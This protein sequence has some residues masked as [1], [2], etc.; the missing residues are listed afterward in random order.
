MIIYVIHST[1][2]N[3]FAFAVTDGW[4]VNT[5]VSLLIIFFFF[6]KGSLPFRH[7]FFTSVAL[8]GID[9]LGEAGMVRNPCFLFWAIE[10]AP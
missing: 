8:Y 9:M 1:E 6:I 2:R 3:D 10:I 4:Y 5:I 7:F